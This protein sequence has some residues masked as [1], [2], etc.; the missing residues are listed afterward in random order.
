MLDITVPKQFSP[1]AAAL[2]SASAIS[3]RRVRSRQQGH[4]ST[5]VRAV[6]TPEIG[7]APMR[8]LILEPTP[9]RVWQGHR[10]TIELH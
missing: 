4:W 2:L 1:R 8:L 7:R 6:G 9:V 5:T 3:S 10:S